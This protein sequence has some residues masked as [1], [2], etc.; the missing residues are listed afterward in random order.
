MR[1]YSRIFARKGSYLPLETS[2]RTIVV[3]E[4]S[5]ASTAGLLHFFQS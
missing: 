5:E 2:M 4:D 3:C 1:L